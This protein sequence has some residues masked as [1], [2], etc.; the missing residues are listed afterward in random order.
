MAR[1]FNELR[2]KMSPESRAR[3]QAGSVNTIRHGRKKGTHQNKKRSTGPQKTRLDR[4]EGIRT[5]S[6]RSC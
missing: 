2:A 3:A 4:P 5:K 1:N 6:S